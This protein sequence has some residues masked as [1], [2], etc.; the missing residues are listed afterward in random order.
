ME[1]TAKKGARR[2]RKSIVFRC[3]AATL[4]LTALCACGRAD[5]APTASVQNVAMGSAVSVQVYG[6]REA[7]ASAAAKDA[8]DAVQ[9][10]DVQVLSRTASSSELYR[11]NAADPADFPVQV[12]AELFD[13]LQRTKEIY[14]ASGGRAAVGCGA[15]TQLW[16]V[17][18]DEFRVPAADEIAQALPLCRDDT[19]TLDAQT[20][21]VSFLPG[22]TLNL[23][24][25][26][27]GAGC[28][29]AAAV[30]R[31]AVAAGTL[32]GGVVSV[33]GSVAT[34]GAWT[35]AGEPWRIGVRDP[36]GDANTYFATLSV[37]EAYIST[38]GSYEKQ[39][40]IDGK[41]YHHILDLT[42][43]YPADTDLVSVTVS[44]QT[45]L[46]SDA[47]STLC[48]LLG[49]QAALPVLES[50]G[51]EALFVYADK[52]VAVTAGLYPAVELTGAAYTL[53]EAA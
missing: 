25:V 7:A 44:A 30:L 5:S 36:F 9:A 45:G 12:S 31:E 27:K 23:G 34:V 16:G 10:L 47:L 40:T 33:G 19:V 2:V 37:G 38:S 15:L 14:S 32:R 1:R 13:V 42:T 6:G 53:R 49:E 28:D 41:T 4:A 50:C 48:F 17:D 39:F 22:Q 51:A 3:L 21:T 43:G 29:K 35:E 11:L 46:E 20:R 26:G 24:S 8:Y 52:T 18:T